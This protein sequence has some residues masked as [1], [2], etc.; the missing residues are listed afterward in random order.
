[1]LATGYSRVAKTAAVAGSRSRYGRAAPLRRRT[2]SACG[3]SG[4]TAGF[5]RARRSATVG[6]PMSAGVEELVDRLVRLLRRIGDGCVAGRDRLE[7][8]HNDLGVV[9]IGPPG[10]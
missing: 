5:A 7:H 6:S 2:L 10:R 3:V 9:H 1:M 8:V 4:V